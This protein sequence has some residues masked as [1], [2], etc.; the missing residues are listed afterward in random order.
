MN[1]GYT[2]HDF[3]SPPFAGMTVVDYYTSRYTKIPRSTW[4]ERIAKGLIRLNGNVLDSGE[5][6]VAVG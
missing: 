1:S 2:F 3:V 6:T 4:Y 5:R